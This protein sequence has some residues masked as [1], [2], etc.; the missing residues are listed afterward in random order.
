MK[1]QLILLAIGIILWTIGMC[2][3]DGVT[4]P[5]LTAYYY[6]IWQL[7]PSHP[8]STWIEGVHYIIIYR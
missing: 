6:P 5:E 4:I 1:F 2:C 7:D 8:D 3:Y